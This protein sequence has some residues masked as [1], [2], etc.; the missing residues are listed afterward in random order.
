MGMR[1][2]A[3]YFADLPLELIDVLELGFLFLELFDVVCVGCVFGLFVCTRCAFTIVI[4][5]NV[6]TS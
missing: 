2:K 3:A 5:N 1:H 6:H 4:V